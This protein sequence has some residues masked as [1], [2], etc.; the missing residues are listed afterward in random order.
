MSITLDGCGHQGVQIIRPNGSAVPYCS[1]YIDHQNRYLNYLN[2][3]FAD[4]SNE[5]CWIFPPRAQINAFVQYYLSHTVRPAALFIILQHAERPSILQL[6][7][8][9]ATQHRIFTGHHLLRKP[10]ANKQAFTR[11][12][13]SGRMHIVSLPCCPKT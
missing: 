11:Y 1:R 4:L 5:Q 10:V 2:L 8:K 12:S 7:L 3:P 13:F 9:T 6:L